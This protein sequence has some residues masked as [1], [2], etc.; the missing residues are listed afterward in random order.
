MDLLAQAT[1]QKHTF[2]VI[3][4]P[5]G[6]KFEKYFGININGR[7]IEYSKNIDKFDSHKHE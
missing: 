6:G 4:L 2:Y 5:Y 1:L 7:V 3:V